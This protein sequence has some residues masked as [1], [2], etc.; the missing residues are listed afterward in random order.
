M[1]RRLAVK[2]AVS[3]SGTVAAMASARAAAA[4]RSRCR[5]SSGSYSGMG[6]VQTR[7]SKSRGVD[8]P[9]GWRSVIFARP[10]AL[11]GA[12]LV[13]EAVDLGALGQTDHFRGHRDALQLVALLGGGQDAFPK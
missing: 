9:C 1:A 7:L 12:L 10:A 13:R 3:D 6:R 2:C 4:A 8:S 5:A 11:V